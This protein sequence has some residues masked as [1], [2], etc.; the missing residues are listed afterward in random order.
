MDITV[1]GGVVG[2]ITGFA[3]ST[4]KITITNCKEEVGVVGDTQYAAINNVN[5][6]IYGREINNH[7]NIA[8]K[9]GQYINTSGTDQKDI[10]VYNA[11]FVKYETNGQNTNSAIYM[12]NNKVVTL[13]QV[14]FEG[15]TNPNYINARLMTL[16]GNNETTKLNLRDVIIDNYNSLNNENI[17]IDN[18]T[19][20]L[21]GN[22]II[23][24]RT[25]TTDALLIRANYGSFIVNSGE[26]IIKDNTLSGG[27]LISATLEGR[28]RCNFKHC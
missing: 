19:V 16:S 6:E 17:F 4:Y 24:N 15:S 20:T 23:S 1:G 12:T 14:S 21:N 26:T 5:A 10:Y 13:E 25:S 8:I 9:A 28:K 3:A 27:R 7:K 11:K 18:G 22:N 2:D